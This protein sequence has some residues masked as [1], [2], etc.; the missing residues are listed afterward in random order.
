[1]R[2]V[3]LE[4]PNCH[5]T[6]EADPSREF[7][8]CSYCGTRVMVDREETRHYYVDEAA[9][10]AAEMN[11]RVRLKELELEE[12]RLQD[13]AERRR[14]VPLALKL[15]PVL[16]VLL[17]AAFFV[18]QVPWILIVGIL[19]LGALLALIGVGVAIFI[20]FFADVAEDVADAGLD[21]LD[22][23]S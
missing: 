16:C 1:M 5:A 2:L 14:R 17:A 6:L 11:G 23:F 20:H 13:C 18:M 22:I 15:I 10:R 3:N 19:G 9:V 4:C 21:V 12:K 8:Y 7:L